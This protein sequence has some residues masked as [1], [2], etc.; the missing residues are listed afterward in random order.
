MGIKIQN[1][2]QQ[3]SGKGGEI[4]FIENPLF[5]SPKIIDP[6]QNTQSQASIAKNIKKRLELHIGIVTKNLHL[7]PDNK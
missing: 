3:T 7:Q 1:P 2:L 6:G 5:I 4:D